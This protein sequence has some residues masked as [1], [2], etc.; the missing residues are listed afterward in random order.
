MCLFPDAGGNCLSLLPRQPGKR[1]HDNV[2]KMLF[3]YC[4]VSS[5]ARIHKGKC[6]CGGGGC[7][8]FVV[9]VDVVFGSE[10]DSGGDFEK[11]TRFFLPFVRQATVSVTDLHS[12]A[13]I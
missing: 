8:C 6:V 1:H 11:A 3:V 4:G 5:L 12:S 2:E 7:C 9:V 13:K 10:K